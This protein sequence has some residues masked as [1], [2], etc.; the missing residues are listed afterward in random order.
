M[1]T[2]GKEHS[3]RM[4]VRGKFAV[5]VLRGAIILVAVG[6]I[7]FFV[8]SGTLGRKLGEASVWV[9]GVQQLN[10]RV[11]EL[12]GKGWIVRTAKWDFFI[13]IDLSA[14]AA[15]GGL[16]VQVSPIYYE[17][18]IDNEFPWS[19]AHEAFGRLFWFGPKWG[20]DYGSG[21]DMKWQ[22]RAV[23]MEED[24]YRGYVVGFRGF[25]GEWIV[26][27]NLSRNAEW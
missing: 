3:A 22:P 18:G 5:R 12:Q 8:G 19:G 17:A 10:A 6:W 26:V 11:F 14:E 24:P 2:F 20:P 1:D 16:S 23:L 4:Q 13:D 9:D 21:A 15:S 27:R 7:G 25:D